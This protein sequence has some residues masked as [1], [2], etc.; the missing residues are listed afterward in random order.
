MKSA[1]SK[2]ETIILLILFVLTAIVV[3]GYRNY[4]LYKPDAFS[5]EGLSE[6]KINSRIGLPELSEKLDSLGV[7]FDEEELYWAGRIH[8]WRFFRPGFYILDETASYPDFLSKLARGIQ[9]PTQVTILPGTDPERF[10]RQLGQVLLADSLDFRLLLTDS[11][12]VASDLGLTGEELFSRMLPNTYQVYWT[13]SAEDVIRK[14]ADEFERTI[15]SKYEE[16]LENS[17]YTLQEVVTLASIVELEAKIRDE[18]PKIAGLYLNRLRRGMPLQADPTVLYALGERRRLLFED[19]QYQ[20][21]YNTYLFR[22]LPP[23]PITNPDE[24]S[25]GAVLFPE[26]HNY[27]YMVASP[28]GS[29]RFSRT[30]EEHRRASD[31]WRRWIR[32]QYRIRDQR[33][34]EESAQ[35]QSD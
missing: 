19:Y 29:H 4:R 8:G 16:E 23:G 18:K 13:S 34:R 28:D 33:E 35:S 31:E 6:V 12:S 2:K 20:H 17:E 7:R 26:E 22:G 14:V 11:S 30:F 3:S 9:D 24:S 21:P 10:S 15:A 25:I 1:F 27:Y 32:E 5:S